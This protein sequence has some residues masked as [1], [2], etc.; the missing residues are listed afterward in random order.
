MPQEFDH[1]Q[2]NTL[3]KSANAG[4]QA[5]QTSVSELPP[6]QQKRLL[7]YV[8]SGGE[9]SLEQR[10][11]ASLAKLAIDPGDDRRCAR[12]VRLAQR[13][14]QNY[15]TPIRDQGGCG[16]CVS[17]GTTATVEA[18]FRIQRGNP[19]LE[20]GS[21]RGVAVLLRRPGV[22]RQLR[23]RLVHDA[24]D[25]RLS[26]TPACRTRHAFPTPIT[27]KPA[28]SARTGR[29]GRPRSPAGTRS[30]APPT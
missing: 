18:M 6:D 22:W 1:D 3:I 8:P 14:R 27:S 2:L 19:G 10:K 24:G 9:E 23:Q 26:R 7:G 11:Q 21:V 12:G 20:R 16:S 13:R 15:I 25:G 29:A 4:W 30:P 5:G 28:A 17:F